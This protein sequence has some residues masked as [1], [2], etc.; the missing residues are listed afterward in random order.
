MNGFKPVIF[1]ILFLCV[2]AAL[3]AYSKH[4]VDMKR[5]GKNVPIDHKLHFLPDYLALDDG[6]TA[7]V[8][9]R[10]RLQP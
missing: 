3:Q 7:P 10:L 2:T 9:L 8:P 1:C 4:N 6:S 5:M